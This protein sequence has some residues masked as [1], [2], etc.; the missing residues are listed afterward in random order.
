MQTTDARINQKTSNLTDLPS[1]D[2]NKWM[3]NIL[4]DEIIEKILFYSNSF[5]LEWNRLVCRKWIVILTKREQEESQLIREFA[6]LICQNLNLTYSQQKKSLNSIANPSKRMPSVIVNASDAQAMRNRKKLEKTALL[7]QLKMIRHESLEQIEENFKTKEFEKF[8]P[9]FH[10]AK[11]YSRSEAERQEDQKNLPWL[12]KEDQFIEEFIALGDF[13]KA[14]EIAERIPSGS[15]A[16]L[17]ERTKRKQTAFER[18]AEALATE[19]RFNTALKLVNLRDKTW[20]PSHG[21]RMSPIDKD[22]ILYHLVKNGIKFNRLNIAQKFLNQ[23][24]I[25]EMGDTNPYLEMATK[26]FFDALQNPQDFESVII[27]AQAI[28]EE[29]RREKALVDIRKELIKRGFLDLVSQT[30]C[31]TPASPG[32]KVADTG[33]HRPSKGSYFHSIE[34]FFEGVFK[35]S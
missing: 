1:T 27:N 24:S 28:V 2:S 4:P 7:N 18:I 35:R 10:L 12:Q 11:F 14:I 25:S 33:L 26:S 3:M 5:E 9:L 21:N 22:F 6:Q 31:L 15:I 20:R 17:Q 32:R 16:I 29:K 8:K 19:G 30:A 23:I 34:N 13:N